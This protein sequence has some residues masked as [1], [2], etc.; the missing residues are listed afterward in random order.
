MQEKPKGMLA[1]ALLLDLLVLKKRSFVFIDLGNPDSAAFAASAMHGHPFDSK[2]TF[3]INRFSDI[4][5]YTNMDETYVEP[6]VE[7]YRAKV[8]SF[9]RN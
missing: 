2:H 4:E 7:D 1:L 8:C 9:Y 5:R 3:Y 6:K